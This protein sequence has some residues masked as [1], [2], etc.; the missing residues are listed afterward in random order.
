M[1]WAFAHYS[2]AVKRGATV[3]ASKGSFPEVSH[4]AFANPDGSYVLVLTNK[5]D[6]LDVP[7]RFQGTSLEAHL[8]A[9]SVT[10]LRWS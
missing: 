7:C 3:I 8:P 4:V 6:A 10:T 9:D 2:K 5:G 1:Y